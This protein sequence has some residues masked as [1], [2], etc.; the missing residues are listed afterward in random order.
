M[1]DPTIPLLGIHAEKTIIQKDTCSSMF[2]ATK[3]F[4]HQNWDKEATQ[5]SIK[6]G[7]IEDVYIYTMEYYYDMKKN[8]IMPFSVT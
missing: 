8:K 7:M 1:Y 6:R 5:M 4:I 2:I 3:L